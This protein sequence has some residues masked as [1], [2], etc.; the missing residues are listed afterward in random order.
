MAKWKR[1]AFQLW[2]P[3]CIYW[4]YSQWMKFHAFN[5]AHC[6]LP[7]FNPY[8]VL[9]LLWHESHTF[10]KNSEILGVFGW[11]DRHT[12]LVWVLVFL[13]NNLE[14]IF[15]KSIEIKKEKKKIRFFFFFLQIVPFPNSLNSQVY[16]PFPTHHKARKRGLS[17]RGPLRA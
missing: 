14:G 15:A 10:N 3:V 2:I 4:E 11:W 5:I 16:H 17:F 6:A 1:L 13:F 9:T 8:C 12:Q 7:T